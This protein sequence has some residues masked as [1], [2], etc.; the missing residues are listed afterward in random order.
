MA[1]PLAAALRSPRRI[2][3]Q[4]AAADDDGCQLAGIVFESVKPGI[5]VRI[6]ALQ[7]TRPVAR[8]YG[9]VTQGLE[10]IG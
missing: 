1:T 3:L 8:V 6:V 5:W 9:L 2:G 7:G 10:T 4:A